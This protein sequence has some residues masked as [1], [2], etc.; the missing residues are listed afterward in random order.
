MSAAKWTAVV[1]LLCLVYG[2]GVFRD[3]AKWEEPRRAL[4]AIEMI[5]SGNY[6]VPHLLGEPY[7]NKPPMFNWLG[8]AVAGNRVERV[9]PAA[10]RIVSL[11]ALAVVCLLLW[12]LGVSGVQSRPDPLVPLVFATMGIVVQYGRA[13]EIDMSLCALTTSALACFEFGRRRRSIVQQWIAPQVFVGLGVLTKMVAP[14]VFYP[15]VLLTAWRRRRNCPFSAAGLVI[16]LMLMSAIVGSWLFLY[17]QRQPLAPLAARWLYEGAHRFHNASPEAGPSMMI[18]HIVAYPFIFVGKALPWSL[19]LVALLWREP[20]RLF[21]EALRDPFLYLAGIVTVVVLLGPAL[22]VEGRGRYL[23]PALPFVSVLVARFIRDGWSAFEERSAQRRE[24]GWMREFVG[25]RRAFSWT[26][27]M[28]LLY[29]TIYVATTE[30]ARARTGY[31]YRA[32]ARELAAVM[33]PSLPVVIDADVSYRLVVPLYRKLGEIPRARPPIDSAYGWVGRSET[34]PPVAARLL[35][36]A[37][38]FRAWRVTDPG[39]GGS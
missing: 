39:G 2:Y 20:R 11:V 33:D 38:T 28:A 8:L 23:M 10:F 35:A 29:A 30:R 6:V 4:I 34:P 36:E 13:G 26:L 16:G 1:A 37:G 27:A 5:T 7:L 24:E 18:G 21:A 15:A 17:S 22:A 19:W 32:Q 31:R 12:R 9:G 14:A 3:P 25:S